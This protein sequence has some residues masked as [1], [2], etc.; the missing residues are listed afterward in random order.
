M[1][2]SSHNFPIDRSDEFFKCGTMNAFCA[3]EEICEWIGIMQVLVAC[4][5]DLSGNMICGPF[6]IV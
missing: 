6:E 1:Q 4:R 3:L 5:I 2:L